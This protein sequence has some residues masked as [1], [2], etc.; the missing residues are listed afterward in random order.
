VKKSDTTSWGGVAEWY[1]THL[2]G[3]T[4]SYHEKVIAPNLL[5]VLDIKKGDRI[6]DIGCGQGFITQKFADLGAAVVGADIGH[7][8][9]ALAKKKYPTI[10]F[11]VAPAHALSFADNHSYDVATI[12]LA[13][14]NI[15]NMSQVFAEVGRVLKPNGRLVLVMNH[16]AFRAPRRTSWGWDE[17]AGVQYRRVDGYLSSATIPIDMHPGKKES[18][19]TISYHRS[20]QDYVKALSKSGFTITRLEEWI[21]HKKSERGPKQLAED[22]ARKE[23]PLFLMIESGIFLRTVKS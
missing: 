5:R 8:L 2:E 19:Q 10:D 23:I 6:I 9:I 15:E 11:H 14:Q 1:D 21:S 12:V 3:T 13:I 17:K 16:P 18:A 22:T 7:E 4:D 20:L